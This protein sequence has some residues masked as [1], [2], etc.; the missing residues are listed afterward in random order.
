LKRLVSLRNQAYLQVSYHYDPAGRLLNRILSNRART[1]YRYDDDNRLVELT[2]RSVSDKLSMTQT[3]GHDRIGNITSITDTSGT[4]DFTYDP[5]YRLTDAD[6]PGTANDVSY[7][8][9]DVGNRLTMTNAAGTLYYIYN[10]DGNRLDEIRQGSAGGPIQVRYVYDDNGNRIEKRDESDTVVQYCFYDQKNRVTT[11]MTATDTYT[12]QYDP[13][14]YRIRKSDGTNANQYLMEGEH[15][16]AVY[17]QTDTIKAKYLRGVVVDEIVNGYYYDA[18][19]AKNNYTFHHDHLQSVTALTGHNGDEEQT[20]KFGPFGGRIS[21]T[22]TSPNILGY[23]GR[24]LDSETGLYYY[25][26]RYYDPKIGRFLSEDPLGFEAGVNFYTYV[27]NNPINANDP[28]GLVV[29]IYASDAFGIPGANHVYVY[30]TET[31]TGVG[32][33]GSSG[34][35]RGDGIGTPQ[36]TLTNP[37]GDPGI[38]VTDLGGLSEKEFMQKVIEYPGWNKGIYFPEID[39][40]HTQLQEAFEYAGASYPGWPTGRFDWDEQIGN[41]VNTVID[42]GQQLWQQTTDFFGGG[43]SSAS[44]GF[45]LYPNKPNTNMMKAVYS[46]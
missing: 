28:S 46:K 36:P 13:N 39:D 16:E 22:G 33:A 4:V 5:L 14:D 26:A 8:Y 44:G 31:K 29:Q 23:T 45:V 19:G 6:Y 30:S 43:N 35:T 27:Q 2:N 11:L 15:Y 3:Y 17:D 32:R 40:C 37:Q 1:D 18:Q 20:V 24:E 25:R 12:F 21:T 34:W 41:A 7:T 10:N 42:K 9:D 38:E